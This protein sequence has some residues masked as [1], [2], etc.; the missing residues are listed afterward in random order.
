MSRLNESYP[1]VSDGTA[2]ALV[3]STVK[4]MGY[5]SSTADCKVVF[6]L[7]NALGFFDKRIVAGRLNSSDLKGIDIFTPILQNEEIKENKLD[8]VAIFLAYFSIHRELH[9]LILNSIKDWHKLLPDKK[10]IPCTDTKYSPGFYTVVSLLDQYE[11]VTPQVLQ[12]LELDLAHVLTHIWV[13]QWL[14]VAQTKQ[15]TQAVQMPLDD[16]NLADLILNEAKLDFVIATSNDLGEFIA[17]KHLQKDPP[18][19][20]FVYKICK[21]ISLFAD[22]IPSS[23]YKLAGQLAIPRGNSPSGLHFDLQVLMELVDHPELNYFQEPHVIS[24][25]HQAANN[26]RRVHFHKLHA[27]LGTLGSVQSLP[28]IINMVQLLLCKFLINAGNVS[29]LIRKADYQL[30][31]H[32]NEKKWF[33][34]KSNNNR[35]QIPLWFE[36]SLLPPLPPIAKSMFIFDNNEHESEQETKSF[37]AITNLLFESLNMIILINTEMLKQYQ[38][39]NIDTLMIDVSDETFSIRHR[40]AEQFLLLYLI[41]IIMASMLSRQLLEA[42]VSILG[43]KRQSIIRKIIFSNTTRLC[44]TLIHS[45]GNIALY[46]LFKLCGKVSTEDILLQDICLELLHQMFFGANGAYCRQLCLENKLTTQALENY[47]TVWNDGSIKYKPFFEK[48]LNMEQPSVNVKILPLSELYQ[49]LPD[50]EEISQILQ[51]KNSSTPKSSA[52]SSMNKENTQQKIG[53][54]SR[55]G[56]VGNSTP[57]THKYNPYSTPSFEPSKPITLAPPVSFSSDSYAANTMGGTPESY[58]M[59]PRNNEMMMGIS[60]TPSDRNNYA[61]VFNGAFGGEPL[62]NLSRTIES[63]GGTPQTPSKGFFNN[64]WDVSPRI[65]VTPNNSKIVSTG[66]NYI[67]GGHNRVKNNSRAQSIHIDDFKSEP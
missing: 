65:T 7:I 23:L 47:I 39:L 57:L 21:R 10:L 32:P 37:T 17:N 28:A 2:K 9:P 58:T 3:S 5:L 16:D 25:L 42:K 38:W 56:N 20:Y 8:L 13:P 4:V 63:L 27:A 31:L 54:T 12:Y 53:L 67:L 66:K 22:W 51:E 33:K 14:Q 36:T 55:S 62:S 46:H 34:N 49:L 6:K 30:Q 44:E 43:E 50:G 11:E 29:E 61:T 40:V 59:D 15:I 64:P 60:S 48:I 35:F 45:Y 26:L 24:L 1:H 41:P 18:M 19:S 52:S